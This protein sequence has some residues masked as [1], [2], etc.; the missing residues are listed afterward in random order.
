MPGEKVHRAKEN[1][2]YYTLMRIAIFVYSEYT[3]ISKSINQDNEQQQKKTQV[4]QL[5]Y[6]LKHSS[7]KKKQKCLRNI[8]TSVQHS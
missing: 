4:I 1:P 5:S 7:Q 8:F 3:K 6:G 2:Y